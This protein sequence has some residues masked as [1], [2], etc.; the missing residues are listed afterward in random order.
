M[1]GSLTLE[2]VRFQLGSPM[3]R[4]QAGSNGI[5][6]DCYFEGGVRAIQTEPTPSLTITGTTFFNFSTSACYFDANVVMSDSHF[7]NN[8][9]P[10]TSQG[11]SISIADNSTSIMNNT[12][13]I[14]SVVTMEPF[15]WQD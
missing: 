6:T 3:I 15:M 7:I 5:I 9:C 14:G 10:S 13:I 8:A 2:G 4:F 12:R 11:S 1:G